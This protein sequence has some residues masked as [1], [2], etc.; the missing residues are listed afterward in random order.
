[1]IEH[2]K[3]ETQELSSQEYLGSNIVFVVGCPRS[4]TT[5]LRKLLASNP[6]VHSGRESNL[7]AWY[8]GSQVRSAKKD[9]KVP[10]GS[11]K[12]PTGL[13]SYFE[14]AEFRAALR[15]Y[16]LKLM[17]P[18]VG[19]LGP[20]EIFVEKTPKH[21]FFIPEIIDMLPQSRIVHILRD[22]RDVVSSLLAASK[23]SWGSDWS[24][25]SARQ[26]AKLWIA[27][28]EAVRSVSME[29]PPG[30]FYE[31][32]YE[33]LGVKTEE[34]L[35]DLSKFLKLEWNEKVLFDAIEKSRAQA[36]KESGKPGGFVRKAKAGSWKED[37]SFSDKLSVWLVARK[38]LRKVG[39]PWNYPW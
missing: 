30:Q 2:E 37:L 8:L 25:K 38:T 5:W 32:R 17:K 6:K 3:E 10:R 27:H 23:K 29:I 33:D 36:K 18:M 21:A 14:E 28:V 35:R 24:P 15:D 19:S 22:G 7:F 26:A 1:M 9:F 13:C 4:G 11:S 34:T 31:L 12:F 20:G 16:M 39:Y